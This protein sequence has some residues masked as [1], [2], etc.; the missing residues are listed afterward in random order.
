MKTKSLILL[1]AFSG[2][3][4]FSS[5]CKKADLLFCHCNVNDLVTTTTVVA[6]GLNSPR[7]LKFG[8]D[9]NLYVAE[10]GIGGS[11]S[12]IGACAQVPPP[13]GP[14]NGSSTGSDI[15]EITNSG[16]KT[17]VADNL[18]SSQTS[19]AG[20]GFVSGV[21]DVAFI[22]NKLYG[23]LAGAGCSHGVP[24]I[25]NGVFQVLP[26]KKWKMIA[27]LSEFVM[28]HPVANPNP[29]DFEPDGTW[30]SM[31]S[32]GNE[33]YAME[34]NHGEI[35]KI[36][37]WGNIS[38]V[39]DI[40]KTKGHIVP[41]T[42]VFHNGEI[43]FANLS[44]FPIT[45]NSNVYKVS[46]DGTISIVALGFS[47]VTGIAFDD[48]GGLYV[49][50]STVGQPFPTPYAGDVVRVDPSGS[51]RVIVSGLSLP[52]AMIFGPDHNLYI[53]NM[54]YGAPAGAGQ[55]LKVPITCSKNNQPFK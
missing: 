42:M 5:G 36:G 53:S 10:G 17:I 40:S 20:G 39:I 8:P 38:R 19:P 51:R 52:T 28:N 16:T 3:I 54:G 48:L 41:T 31:Q 13:V 37:L 7:G 9:G 25:P 55:V 23:I 14:Y 15:I 6:T 34:P 43:Y 46:H 27:N 18:P 47:M 12:S 22:N 2:A 49:L 21:A 11:H 45:G 32:R 35:D 24:S 29:G 26:N 33:L 44:L 1:S 30:Y 50:E 4:I